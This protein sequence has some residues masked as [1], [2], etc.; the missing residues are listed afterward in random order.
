MHEVFKE[1]VSP[2]ALAVLFKKWMKYT[3][4]N[5]SRFS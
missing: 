4:F 3:G 2:V 1:W 5:L